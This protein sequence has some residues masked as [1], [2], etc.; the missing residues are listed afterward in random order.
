MNLKCDKDVKIND[1]VL[2]FFNVLC[3]NIFVKDIIKLMKFFVFL[4]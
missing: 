2:I 4:L 3:I 1:Y